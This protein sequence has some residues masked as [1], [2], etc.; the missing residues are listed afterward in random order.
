MAKLE[1]ATK[2]ISLCTNLIKTYN[3][4]MCTH[5]LLEIGENTLKYDYLKTQNL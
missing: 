2:S 1:S 3:P 4:K 5:I